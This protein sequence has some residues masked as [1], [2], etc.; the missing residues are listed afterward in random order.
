MPTGKCVMPVVKVG[1]VPLNAKLV[2]P[3]RAEFRFK[4]FAKVSFGLWI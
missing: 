4:T 2:E 1:A 3:G